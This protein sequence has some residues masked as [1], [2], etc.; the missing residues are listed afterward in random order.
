MVSR[1]HRGWERR[2]GRCGCSSITA[3]RTTLKDWVLRERERERETSYLLKVDH[4]YPVEPFLLLSFSGSV[5]YSTIANI[6]L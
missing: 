6:Y 5:D 1:N 2:K 3:F 4:A